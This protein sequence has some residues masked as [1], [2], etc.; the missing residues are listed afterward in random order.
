MARAKHAER[1]YIV[2]LG[3]PECETYAQWAY[4]KPINWLAAEQF[5]PAWEMAEEGAVARVEVSPAGEVRVNFTRKGWALGV[6]S[7]EK[8][9]HSLMIGSFLPGVHPLIERE[10]VEYMVEQ[11]A[12]WQAVRGYLIDC[13]PIFAPQRPLFITHATLAYVTDPQA[14]RALANT[15]STTALGFILA[16]A[17]ARQEGKQ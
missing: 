15:L 2:N 17:K 7:I 8:D 3:L 12:R 13:T 16:A 14:W 1:I 5:I 9:G 10:H 4:P 6:V 11:A